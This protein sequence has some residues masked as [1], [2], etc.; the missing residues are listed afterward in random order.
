MGR[1]VALIVVHH[2]M[3]WTDLRQKSNLK[4]L[5]HSIHTPEMRMV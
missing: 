5:K 3:S 2:S 1:Q 4:G